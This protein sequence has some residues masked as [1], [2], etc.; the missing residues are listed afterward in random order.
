MKQFCKYSGVIL[1]NDNLLSGLNVSTKKQISAST[2]MVFH[3]QY[4]IQD[5]LQ[6]ASSKPF[7][8]LTEVQR[9][10]LAVAML[11][12]TGLVKIKTPITV[13]LMPAETTLKIF[14]LLVEACIRIAS[15]YKLWNDLLYKHPTMEVRA[16][17]LDDIDLK[18]FIKAQIFQGTTVL[19]LS[20]SSHSLRAKTNSEKLDDEIEFEYQLKQ[21]LLNHR[22]NRDKYSFEPHMGKYV[23]NEWDTVLKSEQGTRLDSTTRD[24]AH[25]LFHTVPEKVVPSKATVTQIRAIREGIVDTVTLSIAPEDTVTRTYVSLTVGYLDSILDY[26]THV[27]NIFGGITKQ[28]PARLGEA[29]P[30]QYTVNEIAKPDPFKTIEAMPAPINSE[31]TKST[32][33]LVQ[34]ILAKRAAELLAAGGDTNEK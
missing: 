2:H 5:I 18:Q 20:N 21:Q 12:H 9:H 26:L 3:P 29:F 17:N 30:I 10:L 32:N 6:M 24:R 11:K 27:N 19:L 4:K 15:N 23:I 8:Q 25:Y 7:E 16:D 1:Q 34:K 33:P 22:S 31:L 14:G 13:E 28:V